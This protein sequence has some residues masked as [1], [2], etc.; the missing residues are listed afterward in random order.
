MTLELCALSWIF[1]RVSAEPLIIDLRYVFRPHLS[2]C[3]VLVVVDICT[4]SE[5]NTVTLRTAEYR[6]IPCI[7]SSLTLCCLLISFIFPLKP[8]S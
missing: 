4:C 3:A 6:V 1:C 8:V 7:F 5:N 2:K